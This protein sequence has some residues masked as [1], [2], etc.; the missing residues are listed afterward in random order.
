MT[1]CGLLPP[2][3]SV[4]RFR[5]LSAEYFRKYRPTSVDPVNETTSTSGCRPSARPAVS[6]KP[7]TT[8]STPS[9]IPASAA[10]S[11]T[12]SA[13]SGDSSAGLTI[14]ELPA[15][16]AGPSFQP[17]MAAGKF[18]GSTA[19]TTPA[20]SRTISPRLSSPVGEIL[21]NSLSRLSAYQR[22][23]FTTS[24][25][26]RSSQSAIGFP[27]SSASSR[28]IWAAL[29]STRSAKRSSTRLRSA[30][31]SLLHR[32]LSKAARAATTARSMSSAP[33]SATAARAWPV[34]GFS[35]S[36]VC[37]DTES[38]NEPLMKARVG[39]LPVRLVPAVAVL[40]CMPAPCRRGPA[41]RPC[42]A[43]RH[44]GLSTT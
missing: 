42:S 16:R 20:G 15:A 35:V 32:P 1:I 31:A 24:G 38:V 25:R 40:P 37:P 22:S 34:A 29:A 5:L 9:G 19:P 39:V 28:A 7:G 44:G 23:V 18:H 4:I 14:T 11:A 6:P 41:P 30:G 26:S 33:H 36:K 8:F 12:R 43:R 27:A 10:S 17:S 13:L 3:S 2:I 21:P